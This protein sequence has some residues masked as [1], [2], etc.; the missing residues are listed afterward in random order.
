MAAFT[1]YRGRTGLSRT[2]ALITTTLQALIATQLEATCPTSPTDML[3]HELDHALLAASIKDLLIARDIVSAHSNSDLVSSAV[4]E[5]RA[6]LKERNPWCHRVESKGWK[7]TTVVLPGGLRLKLFT[8]YLRPSRKGLVG[9]RR[10]SGKRRQAGAGAFPVLERL[11]ITEG[12]TPLTRSMV[13]RQVVLCSSYDE[14]QD[15]LGREGLILDP[16]TISDI[17]ASTGQRAVEQRDAA[18]ARARSS[19]LP[20][21]SMV[22]GRRIRVSVDGGRARTRRTHFKARKGKNG[23][24]PFTLEWREPRLIT[25]DVL[26]EQGEMDRSFHP[27]YEVT[28]ADADGVFSLLCGLLRLIGAAAAREIVF[29]V[30]GAEWI[31]TRLDALIEA[32]GLPRG[33]VRQVLDYYHA[34]EHI[35]KVLLACKNLKP[36][37]R[38]AL[39]RVLGKELLVEGG[40]A[41]VIRRLR[42]Y[43][44]G[45]R[46][47][48]VQ[49]EIEYLEGHLA[50]MR[51]AE[52]RAAKVPIGSGTVESGV[53]RVINLRFKN[54]SMSFRPDRLPGLLWLRAALK[55]GRWD[56]AVVGVLEGCY[57]LE[58][59]IEGPERRE[60]IDVFMALAA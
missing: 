26:D 40:G 42:G 47:K 51:Y 48:A 27:I 45:R 20:R 5:A 41:E 57:Y 58:P 22:A 18:L 6:R 15:Q 25:I 29:V 30:D 24:R 10:G 8:P 19:P 31:W 2:L 14:A 11:G 9:R 56:E 23:R 46:A 3:D 60:E 21:Q 52:L 7:K 53:R 35:M 28:L 44:R 12:I 38:A 16:K 39:C 55:S 36:E 34:A 49:R 32:A 33:R 50:H 59:S 37:R 43:A 1:V 13:S 17:A 4:A 54:A